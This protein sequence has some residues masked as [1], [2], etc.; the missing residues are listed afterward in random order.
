MK[1]VIAMFAAAVMGLAAMPLP[2]GA[3]ATGETAVAPPATGRARTSPHETINAIVD[4]QGQAG[5]RVVIVYGRPNASLRGGAPRKIW[6]TLVPWGQVWRMGSDEATL[7]IT[8]VP[9]V[10]G[11]VEVPAGTYSLY[12]M[13]ME[14]EAS[15]LIINK[16][17]G[18]WGIPYTPEQKAAELGQVDLKKDTVSSNVDQFTIVV[19]PKQGGGGGTLKLVWETTQYSVDFSVKK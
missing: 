13:P 2:A 17:V 1:P 11:T 10:F 8:E 4:G 15:K 14:N 12:M 16:R 5:K 7:L 19:T 6:G 9:L 18:Q 3:Q